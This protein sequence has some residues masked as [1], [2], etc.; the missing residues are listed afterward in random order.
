MIM[1]AQYDPKPQEVLLGNV[2]L[3]CN[4]GESLKSLETWAKRWS[5]DK[6]ATRRFLILLKKCGNIDTADERKTT[7]IKIINYD[8]YCPLRNADET[9]MKRNRNAVE[10]QLTPDNKDKKV[11]KVNK[12]NN[13][14][15]FPEWLDKEIWAEY[16]KYRKNGKGKFTEYAESLAIKK[17]EKL[18]ES[19]NDPNE[20]IKQ[21]IECGWSGLF[22]LKGDSCNRKETA[23]EWIKRVSQD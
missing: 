1:E 4:R 15:V 13:T 9:Q 17:L 14:L 22:P 23:E 7:R 20:V 18:K 6:S 21:T 2:L 3:I 8:T 16:K 12:E 10:T 19:G 5:W 11:N